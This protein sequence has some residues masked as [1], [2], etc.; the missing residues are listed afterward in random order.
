MTSW[1]GNKIQLIYQSMCKLESSQLQLLD[2]HHLNWDPKQFVDNMDWFLKKIVDN[3]ET[4]ETLEQ[5]EICYIIYSMLLLEQFHFSW[6][7]GKI[8]QACVLSLTLLFQHVECSTTAF[9]ECRLH[10]GA[11]KRS[12]ETRLN[13]VTP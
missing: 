7:A 2:K 4:P 11:H 8:Y 5:I 9:W 10:H 13:S 1:D 12:E 6:F 3:Y